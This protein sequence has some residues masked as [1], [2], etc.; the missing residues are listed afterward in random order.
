MAHTL[1]YPSPIRTGLVGFPTYGS[2][3]SKV[4]FRHPPSQLPTL[5]IRKLHRLYNT[6]LQPSC[7]NRRRMHMQWPAFICF[8]SYEGYPLIIPCHDDLLSFLRWNMIWLVEI[9]SVWLIYSMN[10]KRNK[11]LETDKD[12]FI[13][14]YPSLHETKEKGKLRLLTK[15]LIRLKKWHWMAID[16][17][18]STSTHPITMDNLNREIKA[19][20][21][22][23]D[24]AIRKIKLPPEELK[25]AKSKLA[26]LLKQR[27][28]SEWSYVISKKCAFSGTLIQNKP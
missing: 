7:I 22:L 23:I 2:S 17:A 3:L 20:I 16:Y 25:R 21:A 27:G 26:E 12:G 5:N 6:H 13:R 18:W 19:V 15:L 14:V 28:S 8:S 4:L 11:Y 9:Y 1:P 10:Q 24:A